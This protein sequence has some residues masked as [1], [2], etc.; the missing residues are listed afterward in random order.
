M[1]FNASYFFLTCPWEPPDLEPMDLGVMIPLWIW[2]KDV[3]AWAR[4][5]SPEHI[6]SFSEQQ[7][8]AAIVP[9]QGPISFA[10]RYRSC[11]TSI[12]SRHVNRLNVTMSNWDTADEG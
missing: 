12:L 7:Q 11:L 5:L 4:V 3:S 9:H 10:L 8:S 2:R 6:P 1:D